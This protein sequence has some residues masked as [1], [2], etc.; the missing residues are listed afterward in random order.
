MK[1][2]TPYSLVDCHCFGGMCCLYFWDIYVT[3]RKTVIFI[4]IAVRT[5]DSDI[6]CFVFL[7][8]YM[9]NREL[10]RKSAVLAQRC[11]K[12]ASV[13]II[14]IPDEADT[15]PTDGDLDNLMKTIKGKFNFMLIFFLSHIL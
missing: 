3:N 12:E 9:Q 1:D 8:W 11:L 6:F 15:A 10:K 2:V 13:S 7:K 5:S 14:D 4:D